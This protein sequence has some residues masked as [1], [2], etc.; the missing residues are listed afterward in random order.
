MNYETHITVIAR[1]RRFGADVAISVSDRYSDE[2]ASSFQL[3]I[4]TPRN[5]K[6]VWFDIF[7]SRFVNSYK[8]FPEKY[9]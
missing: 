7:L 6:N 9:Y 4:T 2:I 1:K 8:F 3:K 5:D